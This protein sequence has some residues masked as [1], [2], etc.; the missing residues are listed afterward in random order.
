MDLHI[1]LGRTLH[2]APVKITASNKMTLDE[3]VKEASNNKGM[4]II[5][6]IDCLSPSVLS[7]LEG[8][9]REGRAT[10][11]SEGGIFIDGKLTIIPGAEIEIYDENCK[12]PIHVLC[13]FPS[14]VEMVSFSNWCRMYIKNISLS[15]Q[16]I[17]IS[18]KE[19]QQRVKEAGGLFVP[20]H[21]FTPFKSVYGKG[22]NIFMDEV[23]N[24]EQIDAIELGLSSD[25]NMAVTLPELQPFLFLTNS[26]AHSVK[27]IAREHQVIQSKRPSYQEVEKVIHA[28]GG[29]KIVQNIGL[30]PMLGKYYQTVCKRCLTGEKICDNHDK[31]TIVKGV[32]ERIRELALKQLDDNKRTKKRN[33]RPPY[34]HQAPLEMI[35][36]I[37]PKT[38]E[39]LIN[40]FGSE[41]TILHEIP[42]NELKLVLPDYVAIR[43]DL[44]RRGQLKVKPGGGGKKGKIK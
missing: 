8:Y 42:L 29:R 43:I 14:L 19:L 3:V 40:Q 31:R 26:D 30:S 39:A 20:A 11:L 9:I 36:S 17:Y 16:R 13:Y 33:E 15:T 6:L 7:E 1:H 32:S 10:E 21:V 5:G 25:T 34:L 4:D 35:P 23:F 12:G 22:V 44:M 2:N 27:M 18:A 38:I 24:L 41:M 37:G 28:T